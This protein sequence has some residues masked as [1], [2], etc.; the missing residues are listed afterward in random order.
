MTVLIILI[1]K[2]SFLP[3][4]AGGNFPWITKDGL[5]SKFELNTMTE[6]KASLNNINSLSKLP[7][8]MQ[9]SEFQK[10]QVFLLLVQLHSCQNCFG[11]MKNTRCWK[12]KLL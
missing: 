1:A 10:D 8:Y 7:K 9:Y 2:H 3:G 5:C 6:K 12:S 11:L 4:G